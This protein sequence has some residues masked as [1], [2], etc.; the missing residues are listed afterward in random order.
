M[1][2]VV[3]AFAL[4]GVFGSG[5]AMNHR[6][7]R[8][9]CVSNGYKTQPPERKPRVCF[10]GPASHYKV[11]SYCCVWKRPFRTPEFTTWCLD[12]DN[13]CGLWTRRYP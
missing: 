3:V 13:P 8:D 4:A 12:F 10:T 2:A 7:L 11:R 6:Q 1:L 9:W 5:C